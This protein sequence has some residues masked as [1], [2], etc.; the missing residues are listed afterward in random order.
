MRRDGRGP[1]PAFG[2]GGDHPLVN[3]DGREPAVQRVALRG[4]GGHL[5]VP[6]GF[7]TLDPVLDHLLDFARLQVLG[8]L[9][10]PLFI[11]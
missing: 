10:L 5:L 2:R 7:Q 11:G 4:K 3:L 1:Q 8:F 6:I 9:E